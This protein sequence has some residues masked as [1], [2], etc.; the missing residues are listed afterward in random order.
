M[1]AIFDNATNILN[2]HIRT[3]HDNSPIYT[4]RTTS[5]FLRG[6]KLTLLIDANPAGGSTVVG[7]IHWR[8]RL[9]EVRGEKHK[10]S[11]LKRREGSVFGRTRY[12]RWGS[13]KKEYKITY[14]TV[15]GW[16]ATLAEDSPANDTPANGSPENDSPTKEVTEPNTPPSPLAACL[17]MPHRPHFFR[18]IKAP[19]LEIS[20]VA[21]LDDEVFLLLVLLYSEAKRQD[22]NNITSS[23]DRL[24]S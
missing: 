2:A 19:T 4:V 9:L 23:D 18:K 7:A 12:W 6:R 13:G 1:E 15:E 14:S 20:R 8:Q 24:P 16:K 11:E 22:R 3:L 5:T 17:T 10:W 21:L